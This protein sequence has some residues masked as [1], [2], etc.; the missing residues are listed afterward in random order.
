MRVARQGEMSVGES[1]GPNLPLLNAASLFFLLPLLRF[2]PPP[3]L[4]PVLT[5]FPPTYSQRV[6]LLQRAFMPEQTP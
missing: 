5:L 4:L 2:R 1:P 6:G 3:K